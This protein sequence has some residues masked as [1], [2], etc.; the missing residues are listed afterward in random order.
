MITVLAIA[1][2]MLL[3]TASMAVA[4]GDKAA[5][6]DYD[7][8]GWSNHGSHI[9]EHYVGGEDGNAGGGKPAHFGLGASPGA[10]FCNQHGSNQAQLLPVRP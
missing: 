7:S 3:A 8:S 6:N 10:T 1:A 9:L 5:C 4:G 2:V